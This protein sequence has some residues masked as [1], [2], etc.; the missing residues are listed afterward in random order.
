MP[1]KKKVFKSYPQS[2]FRR[3]LKGKTKLSLTNDNTDMIVYLIY[4]DYLN[5][6]MTEASSTGLTERG[7]EQAH[8]GL[9]KKFR[10]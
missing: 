1:A 8:E 6:L 9:M 3:I 5:K 7:I 4:M 2:S 10:G